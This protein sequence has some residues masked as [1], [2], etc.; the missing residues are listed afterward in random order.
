MTTHSRAF[1]ALM[2]PIALT[3]TLA[4]GWRPLPA[5]VPVTAPAGS[6][7]AAVVGPVQATATP[8]ATPEP[9]PTQACTT[10]NVTL[11]LAGSADAVRVG[12]P[13]TV[14]ARLLNRGCGAIGLP[15]YSFDRQ[16]DPPGL[17]D[18]TPPLTVEHGTTVGVGGSDAASIVLRAQRP[19][20]ARITA[21]VAFRYRE[22]I[23]HWGQADARPVELT[24]M[25]MPL[26]LPWCARGGG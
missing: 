1:A 24:V 11:D 4:M 16:R 17:F 8:A 15:S 23:A 3:A 20:V 25:E 2:V 21:R 10:Y 18:R 22:G 26:A 9:T 19:G 6:G 14:T 5:A 7:P 13:V 12:E